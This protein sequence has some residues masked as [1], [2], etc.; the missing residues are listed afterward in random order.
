MLAMASKEAEW[1]AT[2]GT[3]GTAGYDSTKTGLTELYVAWALPCGGMNF[4]Q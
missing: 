4:D 1:K 2:N 3:K